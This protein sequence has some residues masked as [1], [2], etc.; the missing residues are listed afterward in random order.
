MIDVSF[1]DDK[2]LALINRLQSNLRSLGPEK[3]WADP[4]FKEFWIKVLLTANE[5]LEEED[6]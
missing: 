5:I 1:Y 4:K 2:P 3:H 6:D